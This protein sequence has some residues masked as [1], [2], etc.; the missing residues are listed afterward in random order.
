MYFAIVTIAEEASERATTGQHVEAVLIF[1]MTPYTLD[2][3][4]LVNA[5]NQKSMSG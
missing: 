1:Q 4:Q 5:L 2:C 3:C